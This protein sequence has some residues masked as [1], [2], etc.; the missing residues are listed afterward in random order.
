[1]AVQ[2]VPP[3]CRVCVQA[4]DSTTPQATTPNRKMTL[5]DVSRRVVETEAAAITWFSLLG[6]HDLLGGIWLG[7]MVM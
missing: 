2:R 4:V 7:V 6:A 3:V 1:M 5:I